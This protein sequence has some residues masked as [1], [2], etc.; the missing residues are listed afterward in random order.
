[1]RLLISHKPNPVPFPGSRVVKYI[2]K[3]FVRS[4]SGMPCPVS[5]TDKTMC[6]PWSR[7]VQEV[8]GTS[9]WPRASFNVIEPL[10]E[11]ASR[12]LIIRFRMT[13]WSCTGS[14]MTG[15]RSSSYSVLI[16]MVVGIAARNIRETSLIASTISTLHGS[17]RL[18]RVK[19]NICE[20]RSLARCPAVMTSPR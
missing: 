11:M 9:W 7:S 18:A 17:P 20:M 3:T 16:S 14:A 10:P 4:S 13:C 6:S 8:Q 15:G 5:V 19:V 1:M 12:A 2:S